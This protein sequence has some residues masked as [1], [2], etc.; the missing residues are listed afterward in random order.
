MSD[1]ED[2]VW[3]NAEAR[4]PMTDAP[5]KPLPCPFCGAEMMTFE[6]QPAL[7]IHPKVP[8]ILAHDD[9]GYFVRDWNRRSSASGG[10][11]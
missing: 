8:C 9:A 1:F 3:Q 4:A 5:E 11:P 7:V 10:Q 2:Q 6:T